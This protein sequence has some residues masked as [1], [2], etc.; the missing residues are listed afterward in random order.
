NIDSLLRNAPAAQPVS[1]DALLVEFMN[2]RSEI[3]SIRPQL[4]QQQT[5]ILGRFSNVDAGIQRLFSQAE[6]NLTK[7]LQVF[8][9]EAKEGPRLF[10]LEP[11][12]MS[13]FNPKKWVR[14]K[15]R[16]TLWCEHARLP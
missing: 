16:L 14:E 7:L 6:N 8:T 12:D 10:S 2:M 4:A 13:N 3:Y 11:V 5:A 15:F 9:D 1:M